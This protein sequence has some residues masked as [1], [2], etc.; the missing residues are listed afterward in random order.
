MSSHVQS[1]NDK[2]ESRESQLNTTNQEQP[3]RRAIEAIPNMG[4]SRHASEVEPLAVRGPN[5]DKSASRQSASN[6]DVVD[7]NILNKNDADQSNDDGLLQ[8]RSRRRNESSLHRRLEET[9][10]DSVDCSN[11][12]NSRTGKK[13][14]S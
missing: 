8:A 3:S 7:N 9:D 13:I 2:F 1:D 4:S 6:Q 10:I 14:I 11:V 5:A 12:S